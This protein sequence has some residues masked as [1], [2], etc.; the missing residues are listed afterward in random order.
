M[1]SE[2]SRRV[3]RAACPCAVMRSVDRGNELETG[4]TGMLACQ[5]LNPD[6]GSAQAKAVAVWRRGSFQEQLSFGMKPDRYYSHYQPL[7]HTNLRPP[8][9]Q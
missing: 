7:P 1:L 3:P 8:V 6:G 4:H 2:W 9:S 5:A